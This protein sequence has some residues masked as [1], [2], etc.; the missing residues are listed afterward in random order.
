M[1]DCYG[2]HKILSQPCLDWFRKDYVTVLIVYNHDTLCSFTRFL[3]KSFRLIG[4]YF[5]ANFH[6][7]YCYHVLS[8]GLHKEVFRHFTWCWFWIGIVGNFYLSGTQV[9]SCLL[10]VAF[11]DCQQTW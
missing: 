1:Y 3:G 10:K 5:S 7:F 6:P 9:Q 2:S 4:K 8:D 11:D